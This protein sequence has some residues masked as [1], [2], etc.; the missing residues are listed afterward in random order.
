M[1][2]G[3]S[4]DRAEVIEGVDGFKVVESL[5]RVPEVQQ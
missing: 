5:L 2:V 1:L 3:V 4:I